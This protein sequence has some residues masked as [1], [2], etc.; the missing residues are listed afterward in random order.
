MDFDRNTVDRTLADNNDK[1]VN[2]HFVRLWNGVL[3][4]CQERRRA[5]RVSSRIVKTGLPAG[6]RAGS[7]KANNELI[8][9]SISA[10]DSRCPRLIAAERAMTSATRRVNDVSISPSFP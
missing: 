2:M 3:D 7:G 4:C 8:M 6:V 9:L 5:M 1:H 10:T